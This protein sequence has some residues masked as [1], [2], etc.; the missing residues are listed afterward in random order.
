MKGTTKSARENQYNHKEKAAN[1]ERGARN[2]ETYNNL[3]RRT[4]VEK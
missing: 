4:R 2:A 1:E 3:V